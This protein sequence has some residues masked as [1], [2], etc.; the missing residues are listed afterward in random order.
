MIVKDN[1]E[2]KGLQTTDGALGGL[3]RLPPGQGRLPGQ[4]RARTPAP[5]SSPSPIWPSGPS[6][7][8]KTVNSILPGL[9]RGTPM[10]SDRV[11]R[12]LQRRDG[13]QP[14]PR[15]SGW[16]DSAAIRG[17]RSAAPSSHQALVGIRSTMG[18]TSRAGVLPL[19][20]LARYRRPDGTPR[21]RIPSQSSRR[22]SARDPKRPWSL[23]PAPS[24]LPQDYAP[25]A[26]PATACAAAV[27]G[28]LHQAYERDTTDPENRGA[29]LW[30]PSR[31]CAVPERPSS[32]PATVEGLDAIRRETGRAAPAWASSTTFNRYLCRA[33]RPPSR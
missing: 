1:F 8:M 20:L 4:A 15:A 9:T 24:H 19:S 22:S 12:R 10:P 7:P 14:S 28:V 5:S 23:P 25:V 30:L 13:R 3:G 6:A 21:S 29:S 11:T 31:T 2:T 26:R 32:T 16:W 33:G 17:T 27:I 18:L